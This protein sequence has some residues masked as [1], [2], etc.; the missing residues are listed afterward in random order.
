MITI[1][2]FTDQV[3]AGWMQS[4]LS[5]NEIDSILADA[6]AHSLIGASMLVPI[7]L[8]VPDEKAENAKSLL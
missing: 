1:R 2:E 5:D 3:E 7:K 6:N 4:F 8:Q